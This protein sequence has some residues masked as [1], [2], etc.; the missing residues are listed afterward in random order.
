MNL[1]YLTQL[2]A[3]LGFSRTDAKWVWAEIVGGAALIA[4]NVSDLPYWATYVGFHITDLSVHRISVLATIILALGGH[5]GTSP[6]P[7]VPQK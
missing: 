7:K 5:Y 3:K 1:S 6:L 2:F 4:A